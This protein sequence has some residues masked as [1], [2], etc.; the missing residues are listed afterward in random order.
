MHFRPRSQTVRRGGGGKGGRGEDGE[1][2]GEDG[3]GDVAVTRLVSSGLNCV[4]ES[5]GA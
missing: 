2:G 5:P 1:G 4:P 3:G